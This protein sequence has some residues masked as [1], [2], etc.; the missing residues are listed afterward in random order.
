[1]LRAPAAARR[2]RHD[3]AMSRTS[4]LILIAAGAFALSSALD[5]AAASIFTVLALS[6][7]GT[8]PE[9][10]VEFACA[11]SS[12]QLGSIAA[13]IVWYVV[14]TGLAIGGVL[15][16]L[17]MTL[18]GVLGR[19]QPR[20]ATATFLAMGLGVAGVIVGPPIVLAIM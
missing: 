10:C 2:L 7:P 14:G 19:W 11:L 9:D 16:S 1:M 3:G 4:R 12:D 6:G 20:A 18:V 15:I 13:F 17:T 8:P 5:I